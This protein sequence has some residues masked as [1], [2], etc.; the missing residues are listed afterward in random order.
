MAQFQDISFLNFFRGGGYSHKSGCKIPKVQMFSSQADQLKNSVE[1]YQFFQLRKLLLLQLSFVS[2]TRPL[3]TLSSTKKDKVVLANVDH[4]SVL[5][6]LAVLAWIP[7]SLAV[8]LCSYCSSE[9]CELVLIPSQRNLFG[10]AFYLLHHL[11]AHWPQ[12]SF[13]FVQQ[14]GT[15]AN[16]NKEK[17]QSVIQIKKTNKKYTY[18]EQIWT[19]TKNKYEHIQRTN[20]NKE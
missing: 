11:P 4:C 10:S 12:T 8:L 17:K 13:A 6:F 7:S 14:G 5:A 18:K 9:L 19:H 1:L 15:N 2:L 3:Q 16:A 20:I